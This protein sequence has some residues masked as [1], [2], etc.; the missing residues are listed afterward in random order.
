MLTIR[1]E[2]G[3]AVGGVA[4][5]VNFGNRDGRTAAGR[6]AIQ[7]SLPAWFEDDGTVCAPGAAARPDQAIGDGDR[8]ACRNLHDFQ[9]ALG[10]EAEGLAV[11]RPEREPPSLRAA[12]RPRAQF[13]E[14]AQPELVAGA[15]D[16]RT[17]IG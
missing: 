8:G 17:A 16:E 12:E 3:P 2:V 7:R 9:L 11:G 10:E 14:T 15:E 4:G 1:Q 6:N 13:V 5:L